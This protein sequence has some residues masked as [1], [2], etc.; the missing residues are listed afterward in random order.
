MTIRTCSSC[1][2]PLEKHGGK[3]TGLCYTCYQK[4]YVIKKREKNQEQKKTLSSI[5]C[6]ACGE[7]NYA[8][9]EVHHRSTAYKRFGRSQGISYNIE[10]INLGTAVV[11]CA[12]CHNIFHASFG[13]KNRPFPEVSPE[14][15]KKI[16]LQ[17]RKIGG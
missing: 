9:L 3:R 16:I 15:T 14:E 12:N 5:G 4:A 6:L 17:F 11:L 7:T 10:D 13:G 8:C 1:K 2:E